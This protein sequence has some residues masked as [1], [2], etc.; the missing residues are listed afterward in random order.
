LLLLLLISL[1]ASPTACF[2]VAHPRS[3]VPSCTAL[4]ANPNTL[5]TPD[6]SD[7]QG[8]TP[9]QIIALRKEASKRQ[10]RKLMVEHM[11]QE[12]SPSYTSLCQDLQEHEMIQVRGISREDKKHVAK[13]GEQLAHDLSVELQRVVTVVQIQGHAVTLYSP[14]SNVSNRKILLRTS[15]KE[16]QLE[17]RQKAPR[18]HRGQIIK[19]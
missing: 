8:I 17:Y 5:V 16:G 14:S 11:Y 9:N 3:A 12:D 15:F 18:D 4:S 10:A 2:Q 6:Y 19:E 1:G 13:M 7:R